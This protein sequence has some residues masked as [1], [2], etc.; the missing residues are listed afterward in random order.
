M[1]TSGLAPETAAQ[2][3]PHNGQRPE[4]T[5]DR[6]SSREA[7]MDTGLE[8]YTLGGVRIL[9]GGEPVSGLSTRKAEALL[10]YL[11]STRRP[12][13]REV[14][15]D[16]LWDERSQ[17]QALG[18]LRG[19]LSN[20]HQVVGDSLLISR[21][22]V[23]LNPS[24]PIW[25]DAAE[26]EGNLQAVR[27]QGGLNAQIAIQAAEALRLYRGEFL[28]GFS[29]FD[30]RGFQDWQARQR[31]LLHRL[32]AE[33][34]SALVEN[35][36]QQQEYQVGIGYATRLL[37]L[38]PLMESANRQMMW[39]LSS[40]GQRAAA[41]SQYE[42]F[43]KLLRV[44]LGIEPA[45]ETREL[46]VQI[47]AG[48][49]VFPSDIPQAP[50]P[51]RTPSA[52]D[53]P[54]APGQP[55]F[56]GLQYFD[57][58]DAG[59][60]Y[61][62][63]KVTSRLV[64]AVSRKRF[65]AVVGASGS[66]KSSVVRA[67]LV[68]ALQSC[69]PDAWEIFI[70]SP[71]AQPLESL[72]LHLTRSSESV[73][74]CATLLDD[75]HHDPRSLYLFARRQL[76]ASEKR[77]LVIVD[78][79]EELFTLCRDA[80]ERRMFIEQLL[81]AAQADGSRVHVLIALRA[82]FYD[83]VA[84]YADL[85]QAIA[86]HQEYLGAM[87]VEELRQA[88]E[89]PAK[90]G[91]WE[92]SPGLVD[93]MLHEVGAEADR[94]PEPGALPLLS[95]ALLETWNHRRGRLMNLK[96]YA[97]SGGVH[98]A[99][100]RT[101]ERLY[102]QELSPQQQEIARNIFLRLTELGE[103]TQDTRRR[104]AIQELF[105]PAPYADPKD[106]EEVLVKLADARLIITGEGTAEV[107]HEALIREWP[108]LREWLTK[109][110]EG[111]LV[112]RRLMEA[113]QEWL[114]LEKDAG[115]LYRGAKLAQASEWA[116]AYPQ[117]LNAQEQAF[118]E[119]SQEAAQREEQEREAQR[120][121][122]LKTAQR[123]AETERQRAE[124]QGRSAQNLRRRAWILAGMVALALILAAVALVFERLAMTNAQLADQNMAAA[125]T[126]EQRALGQQ[127][128]AEI[129]K[130]HALD[131]RATA[132]SERLRAEGEAQQRAT[133]E[134]MANQK[135]REAT[136][137]YLTSAAENLLSLD[138]QLSAHLALEAIKADPTYARAENILHQVLPE[139]RLISS[140][141]IK[142]T[143]SITDTF[144]YSPA[145]V[146]R[147]GE[148]YLISRPGGID[149]FDRVSGTHSTLG[150]GQNYY[151][152]YPTQDGRWLLT[153][154]WNENWLNDWLLAVAQVWDIEARKL[155]FTYP[156]LG[157][158]LVQFNLIPPS[159][160]R[161]LLAW[162]QYEDPITHDLSFHVWDATSGKEVFVF[163][164]H[165]APPGGS[166]DFLAASRD[167]KLLATYGTDRFVTLR[168]AKT[169]QE[170]HRFDA[171]SSGVFNADFSPDG[172]QM[173]TGDYDKEIKIWD[174][175]FFSPGPRL[176]HTV[177]CD[178]YLM[179]YSP[180]GNHLA[181]GCA[182][183][184]VR[185]WNPH[186]GD[187]EM[188]LSST[189]ASNPVSF[190]QDSKRLYTSSK[191][192][193]IDEWDL[194]PSREALALTGRM[195]GS[196]SFSPDGSKLALT[197]T[198]GSLYIVNSQTGKTLQ[199]WPAHADWA[200]DIAWSPDGSR[201]ATTNGNS[202]LN[203]TEDMTTKIWDAA[204]G[205]LLKELPTDVISDV[206][207]LAW[208]PD[209][210]R[211]AAS[212]SLLPGKTSLW[213]TASWNLLQTQTKGNS[214]FALAY[215]PD[216]QTIATSDLSGLFVW[217]AVT[218]T[219]VFTRTTGHTPRALAFSPDGKR[220]AATQTVGGILL[221]K[222][223]DNGWDQEPS[224]ISGDQSLFAVA[225]SPD[226]SLLASGDNTGKV[227]VWD[228]NTRQV[229][230]ELQTFTN[231]VI[232]LAFSPDGRR[233]AA[234]SQDEY[235]DQQNLNGRT[236]I[237]VLPQDELIDLVRARLVLPLTTDQCLEYL[238]TETCPAEP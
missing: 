76:A 156:D 16:L 202:I 81:Q 70:L 75:L 17:S 103:G 15:A 123:L 57:V 170:L 197:G 144:G 58:E 213:D 211:L 186:T 205:L 226:G 225:F 214:F 96:A 169:G 212:S 137:R 88:I 26:L 87:S 161:P 7:G 64:E 5:L 122:E 36:I 236:Y 215:S 21:D 133:A 91:G 90:L 77:W 85:R 220:L 158:L 201:I 117:Q 175:T 55:P 37:E 82:D 89:E 218:G 38:D 95:H 208:S 118:L 42:I 46:F 92:F 185:V 6:G 221:F 25:L 183:G 83:H 27:Q 135:S 178:V 41:L 14:L 101:A 125:R 182:D 188:T 63:G 33:G 10:I 24:H 146:V 139:L 121:R 151:T 187:L 136:S 116:Q 171:M 34:L 138:S 112:Q 31:E 140:T 119:A 9:R 191:E 78:Q 230:L 142:E 132:E 94:Q 67:G 79:F 113:A 72:A 68:P 168:D 52:R 97:E 86:S 129:A 194:S 99:I 30:C 4:R 204:T 150:Q 209:S 12:Q 22:Q 165:P 134:A 231:P 47:R 105:P 179:S 160:T 181:A 59:L 114:L 145:W 206:V 1:N 80:G 127:A 43:Q 111:L 98:Q 106:V 233:L 149:V 203:Y 49:Q 120:Q 115:V 153:G 61:G 23:E 192:G 40:S 18:N 219:D 13:P 131:Q 53:E 108:T 210:S 166:N 69:Q 217:D 124:E 60:F 196:K 232:W 130:Q 84:E 207:R 193:T 228:L 200:E 157:L 11:A 71:A 62:R 180:D 195:I 102:S 73:T 141:S 173:A 198:D 32:A 147:D 8:I 50:S 48:K 155:L 110:R 227:L 39:L 148:L 107:A 184:L 74:A 65:L 54:P 189:G 159:P 20:L 29:V 223:T 19:V 237:Y 66:G 152:M 128:T 164:S 35:A 222:Q 44:E 100:A 104:A 216:G 154:Y 234:S 93:L 162:G 224:L 167:G 2:F 126:A 109:N 199:S 235:L 177:S 51:M 143:F 176:E 174:L 28:A 56:K 163:G 45:P 190:S 229:R 3:H 172:K 238:H